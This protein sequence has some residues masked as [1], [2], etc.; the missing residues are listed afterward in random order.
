MNAFDV[1]WW[2]LSL[3]G[4]WAMFGMTAFALYLIW[5]WEDEKK[6]R[7]QELQENQSRREDANK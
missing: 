6:L 2:S 7:R 5:G 3:F 4:Y 1:L